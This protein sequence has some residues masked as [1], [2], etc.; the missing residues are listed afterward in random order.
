MMNLERRLANRHPVALP[1]FFDETVTSTVDVSVQGVRFEWHER[2]EPGTSIQFLLEF[3][4]PSTRVLARCE[5]RVLR[6]DSEGSRFL[7]AATIE[8]IE[9][10]AAT[11]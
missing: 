8:A 3:N 2:V 9:L 11:H 7:V 10:T 6:T 4:P 1:F 5:G